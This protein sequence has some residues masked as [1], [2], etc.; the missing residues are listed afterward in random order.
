MIIVR[1]IAGSLYSRIYK[2]IEF[3]IKTSNRS[4]T[5]I[6][7]KFYNSIIVK[8]S[9]DKFEYEQWFHLPKASFF[10]CP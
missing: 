2:I 4:S 1:A 8:R 5:V 9:Y 6:L 3:R 10:R 7:A